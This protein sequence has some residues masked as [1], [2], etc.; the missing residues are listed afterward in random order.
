MQV[1]IQKA[2]E[3]VK[4]AKIIDFYNANSSQLWDIAGAGTVKV[5]EEYVAEDEVLSYVVA[6]A[7]EEGVDPDEIYAIVYATQECDHPLDPMGFVIFFNENGEIIYS[8]TLE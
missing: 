8:A 7:A 3:I 6:K 1:Q 5:P 2:K 4:K